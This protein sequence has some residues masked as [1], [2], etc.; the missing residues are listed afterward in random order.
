MN[1]QHVVGGQHD[2]ELERI[3]MELERALECEERVLGA[4]A[5]CAAV[6]LVIELARRLLGVDRRCGLGRATGSK[7]CDD[8]HTHRYPRALRRK[9]AG[10]PA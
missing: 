2:V 5:A 4:Q 3:D 6:P 9:R 1:D 10:L 8:D 7:R